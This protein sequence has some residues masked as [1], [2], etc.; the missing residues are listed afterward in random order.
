MKS[1]QVSSCVSVSELSVVGVLPSR[2]K[3]CHKT[4]RASVTIVLDHTVAF[5]FM[6]SLGRWCTFSHDLIQHT[7]TS[8]FC[9]HA[10]ATHSCD[11]GENHIQARPVNWFVFGE[12]SRKTE[13]TLG[14][15]LSPISG[16]IQL[17]LLAKRRTKCLCLIV[18]E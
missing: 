2:S 11:R 8:S 4:S 9:G 13:P 10:R 1:A 12:K 15:H 18:V 7:Q 5:C 14:R 16:M 6:C 3:L 17:L